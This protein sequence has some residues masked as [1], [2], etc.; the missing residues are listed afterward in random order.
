MVPSNLMVSENPLLLRKSHS[1]IG[2]LPKEDSTIHFI[3]AKA[4]IRII[5]GAF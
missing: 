5:T 3:N 1:N 2:N 4:I